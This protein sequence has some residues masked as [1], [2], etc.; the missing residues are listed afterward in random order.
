MNILRLRPE[1]RR[2]THRSSLKI[3]L[4]AGS[5][6]N[7]AR[8][9]ARWEVFLLRLDVQTLYVLR[10]VA[11]SSFVFPPLLLL[12]GWKVFRQDVNP[13]RSDAVDAEM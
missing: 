8:S 3:R 11:M 6:E 1:K 4:V 2:L 5:L 10:F 12:P 13:F 7:S 9:R